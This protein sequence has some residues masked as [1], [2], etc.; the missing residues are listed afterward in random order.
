MK[1]LQIL[2]E[3]N[4]GGV[5]TGT[6]DFAKY[7][8]QKGHQAVVIS[9]GGSLVPLVEQYGAKHFTLPVHK[10]SLW[11]AW[12][13]VKQVRQ[14]I[15]DEKVDIVHARSRVPAWIAYFA[16]RSTNASFITTCHGYYQSRFYSRVMGWSKLVIV[17][18]EVIGRHMIEDYKVPSASIRCIP[19][20][21]DLD[22][23]KKIKKIEK[24]GRPI[25]TVAIVGRI[26]PLKGHTYFLRAMA[27]VARVL[28]YVKIW[29]IGDAPKKKEPYKQE[30]MA[31]SRRLGLSENV[32]FLGNRSD[33]PE[34]LSKVDVVV[35]ST[36]TQEAFGRV[37]LEAQ[38]AGA[39]VVATKVGGV[40]DIIDHEK[41]G[42]LVMP[43]DPEEMA[44]AVIRLLRDKELS[45]SMVE[46]AQKKIKEKYTLEHMA[47]QTLQVYEELQCS[48]NILV[49]KLSSI[50]D[51]VLIAAALKAIR[52]KFPKAKIH[53]LVG[54]ESRKI[55]QNCPQIDG[56]I[57]YDIKGKDKGWWSLF[58]LARRLRKE[59]FDKIIDFQN[60]K[61]SHV[62]SFLTFAKE[63]YG[64]KNGKWGF[65]LT[66]PVKNPEQ[67]ISAV[68]HQFQVLDLL[69]IK[70]P[71]KLALDLWISRKDT[72]Y[73]KELLEA[74][75]LGNAKSIVGLN[76]SASEQWATKNWPVE[77]VARLCDLLSEKNIRLVVTGMEKDREV[78][79]KLLT[80]TKT[81]PAVFIGK[82]DVMQLAAIIKRCKVFITP[83]SAPMHLSAAV[84]TP[85]IALFGPTDSKRHIPPAKDLIVIDK[86]WSCAPCYSGR[87]KVVSHDCMV[88]ITAEEVFKEVC[89]WIDREV[90]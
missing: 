56:L 68:P 9:N 57:I 15:W 51:V 75:W 74:E 55:L 11:T 76:I 48:M 80:L 33:V 67:N 18:S 72:V 21:V 35:L 81:K 27:K 2:P 64:Y 69:G 22:K 12:K 20:S 77:H 19:R 47:S 46:A 53:C 16:C 89:K 84:K 86:H 29:I 26:T 44:D 36:V 32:E 37:I 14:I 43:K 71:S 25:M 50:G 38:S 6:V 78:V 34:L 30:L 66:N 65:L 52:E 31:L 59:R 45:Q 7:L 28:P 24:D 1:V 83:D 88:N 10:K 49:I 90:E 39:P 87:C 17:P 60:N 42:L 58:K 73:A 62:L 3:L 23:F 82:T 85:I 8:M 54:Y 63:S 79:R 70:I 61:R 5:E 40:V 13:M 4:V 41:T